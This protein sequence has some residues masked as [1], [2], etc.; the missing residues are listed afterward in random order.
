MVPT[1]LN[2]FHKAHIDTM[3]MLHSHGYQYIVHTCCSLSS[4][5][6]FCMLC[7]ENAHSLAT[8]IFEDILCQ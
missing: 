6:E 8:F 4:Y 2:L 1:P 7:A 5:P 3:F